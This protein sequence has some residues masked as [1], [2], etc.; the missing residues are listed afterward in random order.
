MLEFTLLFYLIRIHG[1]NPNISNFR[2]VS[3]FRLLYHLVG[4]QSIIPNP[5]NNF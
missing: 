3:E 4:I 2:G 5:S 1:I